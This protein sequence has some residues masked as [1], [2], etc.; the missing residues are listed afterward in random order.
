MLRKP[1]YLALVLVVL[2]VLIVFNLPSQTVAKFK[3]AIGGLFVPLFGLSGS[4]Q[5]TA[6][7]AGNTVLPRSEILRQNEQL[8]RENDQLKL[9]AAQTEEVWRENQ[10]LRQN[11]QWQKQTPGRFKLARVIAH[12]PA[13]WWRTVQID[14]G[15]RDGIRVNMPVR[16]MDGLVGRVS[17]VANTRSQVLLLGDPNLRVGAVIKET[18]DTGVIFSHSSNALENNMVN[19]GFLPRNST[20]RP[21]QLIVTSGEGGI[22]P[23]GI[24]IGQLV[25]SQA[26]E[27]GLS[28]EARVKL[29]ARMSALEDVWV[30]LQ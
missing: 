17:A 12:D 6:D 9:R 18:G 2:L 21:G 7:R 15:S 24:P 5:K 20:L 29:F 14:A 11:I 13:N 1:H 28:V 25:D 16:T 22:F 27:Y 30:V 23:K 3:L 26:A 4:V 8:R 19:L 10:Q